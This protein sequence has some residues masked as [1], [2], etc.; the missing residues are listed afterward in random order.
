MH[1]A[2]LSSSILS[3]SGGKRTGQQLNKLCEG[4]SSIG[5]WDKKP[6]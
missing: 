2:M 4:C 1:A 6:L 3:S 5:S